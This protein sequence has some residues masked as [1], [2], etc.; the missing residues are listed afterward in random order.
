MT[1][2]TT[3]R[4]LLALLFIL[5]TGVLFRLENLDFGVHMLSGGAHSYV[6]AGGRPAAMPALMAF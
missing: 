5:S 6:Y 1:M 2:D 3:R 4:N